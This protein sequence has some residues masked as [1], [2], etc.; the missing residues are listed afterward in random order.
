MLA[1]LLS[2]HP[3]YVERIKTGQK[4]Y[5]YRR[6]AF[7]RAVDRIIIYAT[8]PYSCIVGEAKVFCVLQDSKEKVWEKTHLY[9][10]I[11]KEAYLN[12]FKG[13]E[14]AF[15]YGITDFRIYPERKKLQ[16]IG[17]SRAPQSFYYLKREQYER[18]TRN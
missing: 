10:G 16:D 9:A 8:H 7:R 18:L 5:E 14:T 4:R 6:I 12:Y 15:A 2:I 17:L 11:K 13:R 1:A 3:E